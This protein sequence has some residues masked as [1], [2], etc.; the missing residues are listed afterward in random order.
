MAFYQVELW[1]DGKWDNLPYRKTEARSPKEAAEKRYGKPLLDHGPQSRV[2][3]MVRRL[4]RPSEN[5]M[6]FYEE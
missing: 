1:P 4:D 2:R 3:A 5:S 6:P